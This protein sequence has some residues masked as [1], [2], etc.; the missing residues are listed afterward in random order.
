MQSSA[1]VQIT[2][3]IFLAF[4]YCLEAKRQER[5]V[6]SLL[7]TYQFNKFLLSSAPKPF[8]IVF[9]KQVRKR[10]LDGISTKERQISHHGT[11]EHYQQVTF[12]IVID[13]K[14]HKLKLDRNDGLLSAGIKVKHFEDERRQ[15][16]TQTV[17]HCYYH[18]TIKRDDWSAAA[19]STCNG[20]SGII[21]IS[22]ETYVI[23][24]LEGGS[25]GMDH[26]HIVYKATSSKTEK[27]GNDH[28]KWLPFHELHKGEFLRKLKFLNAQRSRRD[29]PEEVTDKFLKLALVLDNSMYWSLNRSISQMSQYAIQLANIVDLY[30]KELNIR[31]ALTYVELWNRRNR[32]TVSPRLR[33]T[34][35]KFLKF[36]QKHLRDIDHHAAHFLTSIDFEDN[37]VGMA[38]PDAVCTGRASGISKMPNFLEPQQGA[39]ILSHMIGHNLGIKHDEDSK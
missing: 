14:K 3:I 22:N 5:D 21:Q 12:Q 27:C 6:S 33:E 19:V 38:I 2:G 9:P 1:M 16:I 10:G 15:V 31:M 13:R 34:L 11:Y 36:K 20:I 23:Q 37:T 25:E 35:E 8:Q 4:L 26:P 18:G 17:E 39:T 29:T 28:G 24:P 32:I 7:E 30:Y